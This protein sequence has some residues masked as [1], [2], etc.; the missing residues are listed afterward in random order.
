MPTDSHDPHFPLTPRP[1]T[2]PSAPNQPRIPTAVED[3]GALALEEALR[4]SFKI[5]KFLMVVL[6]IFFLASGLFTVNPNEVAI[7]LSFGRPLGTGTE[8]LLKP[9]LHWAFPYP[10]D[11]IVR[12]PVGQSH[13]LVSR[14]CWFSTTP[15]VEAAGLLPAASPSLQPGVE[16]YTLTGDGNIIHVK[17]TLKYR[18]QPSSVLTVVFSLANPTNL[19]QNMLDNSVH[20]AAARSTADDA[21]YLRVSA[22]KELIT[23][24]FKEHLEERRLNLIVET[25]EVQTMA[26]LAVKPAFDEVTTTFNSAITETKRAEIE[27]RSLV[28]SALAQAAEIRNDGFTRSNR[29][30]SSMANYAKSFE[31]LKPHFESNPTLFKQRLLSESLQRVFTNAQ[32][33]FYVPY[34]A[35]GRPRELRLQL[36]REPLKTNTFGTR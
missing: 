22:F 17:T 33:K 3:A 34:R 36:S 5:I 11:E 8:Q 31:E 18:L 10:I 16:G 15:E 24:R 32:E 25:L 20:Y 29:L 28:N 13:T 14:T 4:T 9:G 2:P 12:V 30:V 26:P 35:D 23:Q 21:L 19:L 7:R 6:V 27:A 1:D